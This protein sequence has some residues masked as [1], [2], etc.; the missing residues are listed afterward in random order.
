MRNL[1]SN[2]VSYNRVVKP[3]EELAVS[4]TIKES[5]V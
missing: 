3:L 2:I 4:L 1:F 5:I